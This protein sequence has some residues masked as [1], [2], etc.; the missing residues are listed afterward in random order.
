MNDECIKLVNEIS[1]IDSQDNKR[2]TA[3]NHYQDVR[4]ISFKSD[5]LNWQPGDILVIRPQNSDEQINE[6]FDIFNEHGFD[7]NA[8]T[9]VQLTEIDAGKQKY[10]KYEKKT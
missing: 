5:Q 8:D 6:L 3:E 4:L 7:F 9:I 2:L 10:S 1:S